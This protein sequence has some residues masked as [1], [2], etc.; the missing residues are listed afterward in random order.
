MYTIMRPLWARV[1]RMTTKRVPTSRIFGQT[2]Q[3]GF[4]DFSLLK[5]TFFRK[6]TLP[7][8]PSFMGMNFE[9]PTKRVPTRRVFGHVLRCDFSVVTVEDSVFTKE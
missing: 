1:P 5:T 7:R 9:N 6:P 4:F 8:T 3:S 2:L